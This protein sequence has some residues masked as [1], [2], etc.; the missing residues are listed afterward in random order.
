[1]MKAALTNN[2]KHVKNINKHLKFQSFFVDTCLIFINKS[3]I[4]L[5]V[6]YHLF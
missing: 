6:F 5:S 1:M 2:Q 3:S 4:M